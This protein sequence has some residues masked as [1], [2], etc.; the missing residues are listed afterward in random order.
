MKRLLY[1]STLLLTTATANAQ[2]FIDSL[3]EKFSGS[4]QLMQEKLYVHTDKEFYFTGETIWFKIYDVD[5]S[6]HEL[7]DVSKLAYVELI[8]ADHKPVAQLKVELDTGT[9]QGYVELPSSIMS[10]NYLLRAYTNW[11]KN[12]GPDYFFEKKISVVNAYRNGIAGTKDTSKNRIQFFPEGGNLVNGLESKVAFE[13][14]ANEK[15][16]DVFGVIVNDKNDTVT[17][18]TSLRFGLGHFSFTPRDANSYR[19]VCYWKDGSLSVQSLPK[20]YN[21]G[22]VVKLNDD[23]K[24]L[25]LQVASVGINENS[26]ICLLVHSRQQLKLATISAP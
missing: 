9:G 26:M 5:A 2:S 3:R 15:G 18:F 24:Q 6:F 14:T 10:G 1:I 20:A 7:M 21:S 25:N 4:I 23:G 12:F 11:M 16:D 13:A 22:Y 8:S 19:A 17:R